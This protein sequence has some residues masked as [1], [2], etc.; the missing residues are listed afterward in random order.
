MRSF[1]EVFEEAIQQFSG[2]QN[3]LAGNKMLKTAHDLLIKLEQ[4]QPNSSNMIVGGAVRDLILG[5]EPKDIDIATSIDM[6]T[7]A[8]H[9]Q[10]DEI[11]K[12]KNFGILN[13]HFGDYT[14]EVSHF[15]NN[16]SGEM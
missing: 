15:R 14:F 13:V 3:A 2:W 6:D 4:I 11:G 1:S 9:F 16:I 12:S 7:I 10:V 8:Q 5:N